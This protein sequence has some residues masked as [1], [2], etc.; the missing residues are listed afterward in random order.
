[1]FVLDDTLPR[2]RP[3]LARAIMKNPL[4]G[5]PQVAFALPAAPGLD[6]AFTMM[7]GEFCGNATR[8]YGMWL[9]RQRGQQGKLLLQVSG[10]DHPV[11]VW[12]EDDTASAQMPLPQLVRQETAAGVP[13]TLVHLGGIAHLVV[14][15][16]PPEE[17]FF[18]EAEPCF[19]AFPELEAYGVIFLQGKHVT[20]LVKVV[21][22]DT[23]AWEGSCGS[24]S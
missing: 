17:S 15:D 19:A 18:A 7:G 22:T 12:A 16:I 6:G 4:W 9:A 24:G 1:M 8:A 23:L 10:C 14:E 20:P 21:T 5:V 2:E 11:E 13:C 3:A